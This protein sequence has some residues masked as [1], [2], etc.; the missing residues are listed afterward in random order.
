MVKTGR[1]DISLHEYGLYEFKLHKNKEKN[2]K[3]HL[4]GSFFLIVDKL[5]KIYSK[6]DEIYYPFNLYKINSDIELELKF[7]ANEDTDFKILLLNESISEERVKFIDLN[8]DRLDMNAENDVDYLLTYNKDNNAFIINI[9]EDKVYEVTAIDSN[10]KYTKFQA[11]STVLNKAI[12]SSVV[13]LIRLNDYKNRDLDVNKFINHYTIE[14]NTKYIFTAKNCTH[15]YISSSDTMSIEF[16]NG[17]IVPLN[18]VVKVSGLIKIESIRS[19]SITFYV[20]CLIDNID[21]YFI[22]SK[23]CEV[24]FSTNDY[25]YYNH[26]FSPSHK[27]LVVFANSDPSDTQFNFVS[28]GL[29]QHSL[30]IYTTFDNNKPLWTNNGSKSGRYVTSY[31]NIVLFYNGTN[32]SDSVYLRIK[33]VEPNTV[34]EMIFKGG[35]YTSVIE[36]YSEKHIDLL[37]GQ[38]F[39]V[40][41]FN[42]I[43]A[44]FIGNGRNVNLTVNNPGYRVLT[45][46]KVIIY[47]INDTQNTIE[48][49]SLFS[50]IDRCQ[51][52]DIQ[53]AP[54]PSYTIKES[55]AVFN[56]SFKLNINYCA[57]LIPHY[58]QKTLVDSNFGNVLYLDVPDIE[59]KYQLPSDYKEYFFSNMSEL[60]IF[61]NTN[62]Y[63]PTHFPYLYVSYRGNLTNISSFIDSHYSLKNDTLVKTSALHL[64]YEMLYISMKRIAILYGLTFAYSALFG[65][66]VFIFFL[67]IYPLLKKKR[68]RRLQSNDE[69]SPP[70]HMR[71]SNKTYQSHVNYTDSDD[72]D[73]IDD[74]ESPE[75]HPHLTNPYLL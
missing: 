71:V 61:I 18:R 38:I 6:N 47:N 65:F 29:S 5:T 42:G 3:F 62:N 32:V 20:F 2:L 75:S 1:G 70:S 56:V 64:D 59:N 34:S 16:D 15:V 7:K 31:H 28:S 55:R 66:N 51:Q 57:W 12:H 10:N 8:V 52:F 39:M 72:V 49:T 60:F 25:M 4:N 11:N 74:C 24:S 27:F 33:P 48:I 23:N 54:R 67:F 45:L 46:S 68:C 53:I 36:A 21:I 14:A 41:H 40:K 69:N 30:S 58:S 17:E 26:T 19:A 63:Y 13:N 43:V 50:N 37:P 9:S 44:N 35:T 22:D 73:D